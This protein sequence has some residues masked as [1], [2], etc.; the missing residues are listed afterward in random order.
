VRRGLK[1]ALSSFPN[2]TGRGQAPYRDGDRPLHPT[3][4]A[5]ASSEGTQGPKFLGAELRILPSP[6]LRQTNSDFQNTVSARRT[7]T[8]SRQVVV[9]R[10]R[11]ARRSGSPTGS[12]PEWRGRHRDEIENAPSPRSRQRTQQRREAE[13]ADDQAPTDRHRRHAAQ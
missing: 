2:R 6:W 1:E 10:G 13:V 3:G 8:G 9:R 12:S 4:G 11:F 7:M 5:A